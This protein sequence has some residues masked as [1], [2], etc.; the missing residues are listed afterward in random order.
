[1]T[2]KG[3][4]IAV[5]HFNFLLTYF[6]LCFMW[7][8]FF[9]MLPV[10]T[11]IERCNVYDCYSLLVDYACRALVISGFFSSVIRLI[12]REMTYVAF[13][14]RTNSILK[15]EGKQRSSLGSLSIG[16]GSKMG[17]K[18]CPVPFCNR[19]LGSSVSHM[20]GK[21]DCFSPRSRALSAVEQNR[22]AKGL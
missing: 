20:F 13:G 6:T 9:K 17:H 3:T 19:N 11:H 7:I 21:S 12:P 8:N 4:P 16:F 1:M 2:T 18:E 14:R 15:A 10:R 22:K 5:L